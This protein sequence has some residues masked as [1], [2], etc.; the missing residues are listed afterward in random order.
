MGEGPIVLLDGDGPEAEQLTEDARDLLGFVAQRPE[1]ADFEGPI[2]LSVVLTD[3][4][5]I[6]PLNAK[7][8]DRDEATDVLSFPLEEGPILGDV[9]IS[10]ETAA[11]RLNEEWTLRDELLFLLI[12]GVLHLLGHDHM[13]ADERTVMEAAE[14]SLWTA[15][16]RPGTL[17]ASDGS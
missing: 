2:E 12:H 16:G 17:R 4:A 3:D 14:Q 5:G 7:W 8:R 11:R 9:V 13:E 10:T 15:M 1:C 6:R